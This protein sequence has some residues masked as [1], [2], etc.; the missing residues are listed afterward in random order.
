MACEAGSL[1]EDCRHYPRQDCW[2]LHSLSW[3][4]NIS[5]QHKAL[6]P[7]GWWEH[8]TEGSGQKLWFP[9]SEKLFTEK[10]SSSAMG[11]APYQTGLLNK[12]TLGKWPN[13]TLVPSVWTIQHLS[14]SLPYKHTCNMCF[15]WALKDYLSQGRVFCNV[16][17]CYFKSPFKIKQATLPHVSLGEGTKRHN[18]C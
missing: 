9:S 11:E 6:S 18:R 17:F 10:H 12:L 5:G 8:Q 13:S 14:V 1:S 2:E 15:C 4:A 3:M 16:L 7:R